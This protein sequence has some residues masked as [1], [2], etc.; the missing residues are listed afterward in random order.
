M[1]MTLL[2]AI[3]PSALPRFKLGVTLL[4]R[5]TYHCGVQLL[6]FDSCVVSGELPVD[7]LVQFDALVGEQ[8]HRPTA[9]T[10]MHAEQAMTINR[11]L[12]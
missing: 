3:N 10:F 6:G 4:P 1:V 8:L 11:A 12:A 2:A 5:Q 9:S 7:A